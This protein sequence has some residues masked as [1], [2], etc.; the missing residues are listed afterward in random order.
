MTR[1]TEHA[2][3]REAEIFA[4]AREL[5]RGAGR[6]AFLEKACAGDT[7]LRRRIDDLL[8][9]EDDAE[10]FFAATGSPERRRDASRENDWS[11]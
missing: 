2:L 7:E 6:D 10:R 3:E 9:V 4:A 8:A 5:Q 1:P 11:K